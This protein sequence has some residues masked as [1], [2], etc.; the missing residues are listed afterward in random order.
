MWQVVWLC[1][2]PRSRKEIENAHS[3]YEASLGV[4]S[5]RKSKSTD[6]MWRSHSRKPL[7]SILRQRK[8]HE[9][10]QNFKI[11]LSLIENGFLLLFFLQLFHLLWDFHTWCMFGGWYSLYLLE[12]CRKELWTIIYFYAVYLSVNL[13]FFN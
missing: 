1:A 5:E 13:S 6:G 9:R 3:S 7:V 4:G 12:F 11:R 8:L 2:F 10:Q